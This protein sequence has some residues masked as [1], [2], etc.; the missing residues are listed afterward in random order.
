MQVCGQILSHDFDFP[1][2]D[3]DFRKLL[4]R[5]LIDRMGRAGGFTATKPTREGIF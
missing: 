5:S 2:E 3:Y 4:I 1:V